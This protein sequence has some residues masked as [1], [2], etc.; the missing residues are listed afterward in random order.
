MDASPVSPIDRIDLGS[1][2]YRQQDS[3]QTLAEGLAEYYARNQGRVTPPEQMSPESR[4]L[5]YSHDIG[6]VVFGLDT[7]LA[8]EAMADTRIML[9][10]NVGW[11]RYSAYL[12]GDAQAK[13]I[14]KQIGYGT[15]IWASL[16][17]TPRIL[18]A[19]GEAMRMRTRWPW[20]PPPAYF[21]RSLADLRRQYG[22]HVI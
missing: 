14:F 17:A 11:R 18:K 21:E 12:T 16:L 7:T 6:H 10:S 3:S 20:E 2:R 22:I 9:S 15:V 13:A 1:C 5:F 4:A 19:V 8:D